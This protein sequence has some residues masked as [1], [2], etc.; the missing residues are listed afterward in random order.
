[1]ASRDEV[2]AVLHYTARAYP[3]FEPTPS[4]LGVYVDRLIDIDGAALMAAANRHIDSSK[5]FPTV[6]ELRQSAHVATE[7]ADG[8]PNADDAWAWVTDHAAM[9]GEL[10]RPDDPALSR[11][12][13]ARKC[14][15]IVGG[16]ALLGQTQ[17][18]QLHWIEK[19]FAEAYQ[20][21]TDYAAPVVSIG[22]GAP[23]ALPEVNLKRID[24]G[25]S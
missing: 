14:V 15:R 12:D 20:N 16:W 7:L 18:D 25:K 8:V 21:C 22:T 1:M 5:W 17:F 4:V 11:F 19:R 10:D 6:A 24:G 23:V 13:R 9:S 3:R 2:L